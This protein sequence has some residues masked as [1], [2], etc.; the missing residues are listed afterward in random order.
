VQQSIRGAVS[1]QTEEAARTRQ[2]GA[3][4]SSK[5]RFCMHEIKW[6]TASEEGIINKS[7][8]HTQLDMNRARGMLAV[9]AT[10]RELITL[11]EKEPWST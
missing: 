9:R 8:A 3:K 6:G 11:Q 4:E 10:R 5:G 7:G 1:E 2:H